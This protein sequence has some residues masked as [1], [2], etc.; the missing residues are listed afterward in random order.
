[1]ASDK[2]VNRTGILLSIFIIIISL[3]YGFFIGAILFGLVVT[4]LVLFV[5]FVYLFSRLV[6]AVERIAERE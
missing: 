6:F 4:V 3:A 2:S 5:W 1:M